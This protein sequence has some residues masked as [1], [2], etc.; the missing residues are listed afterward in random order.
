MTIKLKN[1]VMELAYKGN[2]GVMEVAAFY[3]VAT[4]A[5]RKQLQTLID[6]ANWK[7]AWALIQQVTGTK[8]DGVEEAQYIDPTNT[9]V[10]AILNPDT[11]ASFERSRKWSGS[12]EI[13]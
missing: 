12:M 3:D 1:L 9:D 13:T 10:D 8:L 5:Q 2:L 4:N 6:A 11:S 7:E